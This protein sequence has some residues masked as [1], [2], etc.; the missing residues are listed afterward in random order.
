MPQVQLG[1]DPKATA[2]AIR[3]F[4][5]YG[6]IDTSASDEEALQVYLA[7]VVTSLLDRSSDRVTGKRKKGFYRRG[8]GR[9]DSKAVPQLQYHGNFAHLSDEQTP[10]LEAG[11]PWVEL[12]NAPKWLNFIPVVPYIMIDAR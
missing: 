10:L 3:T 9:W 6:R 5:E 4:R 8:K 11:D 7:D 2:A 1:L 12:P